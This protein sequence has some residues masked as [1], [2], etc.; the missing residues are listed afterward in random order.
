MGWK[1]FAELFSG[2]VDPNQGWSFNIVSESYINFGY[3]GA[4]FVFFV[5]GYLAENLYLQSLHY[6]SIFA[7]PAYAVS[8]VILC[9]ALRTD[10]QGTFKFAIYSF[11]FFKLANILAIYRKSRN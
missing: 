8:V 6:R 3:L 4:T 1:I 5:F 2:G 9:Y 11:I 7:L 10:F